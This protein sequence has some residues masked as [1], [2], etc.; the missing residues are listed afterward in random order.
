MF[1]KNDC[2]LLHYCP[3][4]TIYCCFRFQIRTTFI[5]FHCIWKLSN[6]IR[7]I[8]FYLWFIWVLWLM[9]YLILRQEVDLM[10]A[11]ASIQA[12]REQVMDFTHP[13]YYDTTTILIK[14]PDPDEN[15]MFTLAK[16]FK[17]EVI[18][19]I[20]FVLPVSAFLLFLIEKLS[21]YY[22]IHGSEG[23]Q[24]YQMSFWYMFGALLTQG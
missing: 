8:F 10:V 16:P 17:I 6:L 3:V 13:F 9:L 2:T 20:F 22:K 24:N 23:K 11:G 18:V 19:C 15:K 4:I 7:C 1:R 21:P 5:N 12:S 14:L